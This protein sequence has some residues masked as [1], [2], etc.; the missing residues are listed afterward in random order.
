VARL[1]ERVTRVLGFYDPLLSIDTHD[2]RGKDELPFLNP[3]M[4]ESPAH[5]QITWS[6]C[7]IAP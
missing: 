7:L 3:L 2:R 5:Q 1:A 4:A 6:Q